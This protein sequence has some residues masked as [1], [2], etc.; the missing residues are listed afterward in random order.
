MKKSPCICVIWTPTSMLVEAGTQVLTNV[1][2]V[3][4]Y[5]YGTSLNQVALEIVPG[6]PH[7]FLAFCQVQR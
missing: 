2:S 7:G 6:M 1:L 5:I 4:S 3:R